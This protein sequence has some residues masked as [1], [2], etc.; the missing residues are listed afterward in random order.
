MV[1]DRSRTRAQKLTKRLQFH[2]G[3]VGGSLRLVIIGVSQPM[4]R[5][6]GLVR[7]SRVESS[8]HFIISI[9]VYRKQRIRM[10]F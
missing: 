1:G 9:S 4:N 7:D 5:V 8:G 10:C 3:F 2:K 6:S